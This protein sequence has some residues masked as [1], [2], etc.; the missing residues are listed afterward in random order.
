MTDL[1]YT[2][3]QKRILSVLSDGM[4]HLHEELRGCLNDELS[5]DVNLR[6]HLCLLRKKVRTL[7]QDI[8]CELKGGKS[9]WRHIIVVPITDLH[10]LNGKAD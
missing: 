7:G 6:M 4:P 2:P 9:Y 3:T 5:C 1:K 8:I 10:K